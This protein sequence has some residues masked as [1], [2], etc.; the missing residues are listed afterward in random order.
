MPLA[1]TGAGNALLGVGHALQHLHLRHLVREQR[2]LGADAGLDF[3]HRLLVRGGV[4]LTHQRTD[5]RQPA[6]SGCHR[7][8]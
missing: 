2:V 4:D 1:V 7:V 3:L 5:L 8:L 6:R